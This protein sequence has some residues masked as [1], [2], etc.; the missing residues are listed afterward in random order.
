MLPARWKNPPCRNIAVKIEPAG[1]THGVAFDARIAEQHAR[2]EAEQRD[3]RLLR[4]RRQRQ[5]PEIDRHAREDQCRIVTTGMPRTGLSSRIGIMRLGRERAG[6][7]AASSAAARSHG[8]LRRAAPFPRASDSGTVFSTI[9]AAREILLERAARAQHRQRNAALLRHDLLDGRAIDRDAAAACAGP[10]ERASQRG[11][12]FGD[13]IVLLL[14]RAAGE[15]R[16]RAARRANPRARAGSRAAP[17]CRARRARTALR[18]PRGTG[19][20]SRGSSACRRRPA[21]SC[22]ESDSPAAINVIAY[23]PSGLS[24]PGCTTL[25]S[26]SPRSACSLRTTPARTRPDRV[27]LR[28]LRFAERR[29]PALGAD[30]DRMTSR[31]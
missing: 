28:D 4:L 25:G 23:A 3:R 20:C 5:L 18:C 19:E 2:H 15:P 12:G 14:R 22:R 13:E 31:P 11:I 16:G 17:R 29:P 21:C 1:D 6:P 7:R 24:G 9:R 30:A 10:L 27:P 8:R 26:G